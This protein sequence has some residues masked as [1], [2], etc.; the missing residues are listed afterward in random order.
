LISSSP[1]VIL[2]ERTKKKKIKNHSEAGIAQSVERRTE[3]P[4]VGG[5]IPSPGIPVAP[6]KNY[7][8]GSMKHTFFIVAFLLLIS[9]LPAYS[10]VNVL[11]GASEAT[12]KIGGV[13]QV[14]ADFGDKGDGRFTTADDRFYLRRARLNANGT[15]LEHFDFRLE[16]DLSGTLSNN[17][18]NA[19]NLRAQMTDGYVTWNRYS[20]AKIRGGQFKSPYGYEQMYSDPNHPTIEHSLVNDRLTVGRQ[21]GAEV[22]GDLFGKRVSYWTAIL[23][24]NNLD[25]SFNDNDQF[26]YVERGSAVLWQGK[27]FGKDSKLAI[28]GDAFFS[29]DKNLTGQS[30]EFQ[31]LANTFTG[32]RRGVGIDSQA[33]IGRADLWVE[34]LAV[35]F[36]PEDQI[37]REE[38]TPH[39]WYF[40]AGYMITPKLQGLVRYEDFNPD[41][42]IG[43]TN[44]WTLCMT[45]FIKGDDLK[46]M[47]NYL[48]SDVLGLEDTQN[49][50]L[51]R[52]QIMF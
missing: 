7:K 10:D 1:F 19:S 27:A 26:M 37:P 38:F 22:I 2:F 17:F 21:L 18:V 16:L 25:N 51:A 32:K 5:S 33:H 49:K 3:N 48:R 20:M 40:L 31:F 9:T 12:L 46:I 47:V 44:T 8:R 13:L 45:Y 30:S 36:R 15:F 50:L 4:C 28:S 14:Q 24:G 42:D 29:E 35:R 23:N 34:Y 39:G 52:F 43:T 11:T 41:L 6:Y